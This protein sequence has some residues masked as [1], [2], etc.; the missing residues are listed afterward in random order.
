VGRTSFTVSLAL[1]RSIPAWARIASSPARVEITDVTSRDCE[2]VA[3]PRI[4]R[5]EMVGTGRSNRLVGSPQSDSICALPGNDEIYALAG[6]DAVDAG[7]GNDTVVGGPG[8]DLLLGG[9]GY[10][11]IFAR[12]GAR[13][14]IRCGAQYDVV[15]ADRFD[16]AA[17][18][19]EQVRRR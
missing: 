19:C 18:N 7:A 13:D 14:R 10:D 15:F 2:L 3:T 17:R 12:D 4:A 16:V 1:T 5:C 8:R 9:D 6:A 11:T